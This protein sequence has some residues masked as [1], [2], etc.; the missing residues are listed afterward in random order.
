MPIA[1][2]P[3]DIRLSKRKLK[4][5]ILYSL[6]LEEGKQLGLEEGKKIGLKEGKQIRLEE[7]F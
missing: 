5:D 2:R 3:V 6:G 1:V 7:G 4:K